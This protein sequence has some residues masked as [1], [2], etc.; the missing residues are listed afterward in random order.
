MD[1]TLKHSDS[2]FF[3]ATPFGVARDESIESR[4]QIQQIKIGAETFNLDPSLVHA[5]TEIAALETNLSPTNRLTL[6]ML[7]VAS[8]VAL[9]EGSTRLPVVGEESREPMRR[10]LTPLCGD[11]FGDNGVLTIASQIRELLALD[12]AATV[13]GRSPDDYKPLLYIEPF[14]YHQKVY[15]AESRLVESI[16]PR[17][18]AEH[19]VYSKAD[20]QQAL[21]DVLARPAILGGREA[22]ISDEQRAAIIS[23]AGRGLALISGEPGT[24]KTSIVLTL[25]RVLLRL[26]LKPSDIALAAPTGKGAYRMSE[27]L[28]QGI[29]SVHDSAPADELLKTQFPEA[30]TVHR[31]L[32]YS[33]VRRTF[34][35]HR[36]NPLAAAVIVI[37][38]SSMLDL[39]VAERL[40]SSLRRDARLILLGD[41]Y[42]LPS[43]TAGA[44]F[45]DLV[46]V[47]EQRCPEVC[48]RLTRNYRTTN[49]KSGDEILD[50]AAKI[51]AGTIDLHGGA[52]LIPKRETPDKLRFA[53]VESLVNAK[54]ISP[55]LDCWYADRI[56]PTKLRT[57]TEN[58]T[59]GFDPAAVLEL[60]E[61]FNRIP[62]SRILCA[63]RALPTGTDAINAAL[64]GRAARDTRYSRN[65]WGFLPGEPV[66]VVRNDYERMLF[67]G[68]QGVVANVASPGQGETLKAVFSQNNQY[69]AFHLAALRQSLELSYA[70]T[71]HKAQGSEFETVAIVLPVKDLPILTR[72]LLYTAVSRARNSVIILGDQS[73]LANAIARKEERFSGLSES[74]LSAS[75]S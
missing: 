38:E 25:L 37:D 9:G 55:F 63:T 58:G 47:S 4:R 12:R 1:S 57:L 42:Q 72:E 61:F 5:A 31:L 36:N 19:K 3:L 11:Q 51:N 33:R 18:E 24:G 45:R 71:I 8:M 75:Q 32:G 54:Q 29:T 73:I 62:L 16:R 67:N 28:R 49:S 2:P 41:A 40:L 27:S 30:K 52:I 65:R 74:L 69:V 13:I 66:M 20:I 17:L 6:I 68:D 50:F 35:H 22:V 53:G 64:H 15:A 60:Q 59:G 34:A 26:G 46:S 70:T 23:T 56:R 48:S 14:I 44:V 10:I 7:L 21:D 39:T 43:V